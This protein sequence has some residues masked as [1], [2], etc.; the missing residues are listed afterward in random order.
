M[1]TY[2]KE[3][4]QPSYISIIPANVRYDKTLK[5]NEKLMFG[6]ITSLSNK[7]GYCWATNE[8]FASLYGVSKFTVSRWINKLVKRGYVNSELIIS[9][10]T[11]DIL[12]IT[13]LLMK[14][15][16]ALSTE[17]AITLSIK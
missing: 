14:K 7:E 9:K 1:K 8:Y 11:K 10:K 16:I 6:E 17:K 13:Y 5:P 15:A 2:D 3:R 4:T 12:F